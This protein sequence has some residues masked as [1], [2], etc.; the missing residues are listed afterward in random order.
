MGFDR[1]NLHISVV[2]RM[3]GPQELFAD[4]ITQKQDTGKLLS[5]C[6]PAFNWLL[7][8]RATTCVYSMAPCHVHWLS[9][10]HGSAAWVAL[11]S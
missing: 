9:A 11:T 8:D 3:G 7:P 6:A 1:D 2:K 4:L 10:D 5:R